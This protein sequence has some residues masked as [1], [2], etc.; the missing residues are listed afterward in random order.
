[1]YGT[2]L[3]RSCI[4]AALGRTGPTG[5]PALAV[6]LPLTA[7]AAF[8]I[9]PTLPRTSGHSGPGLSGRVGTMRR[10]ACLLALV[11]AAGLAGGCVERKYTVYTDPPNALVLVNNT[12]L[13]ASPADGSFV[14]YGKYNF[15][16]M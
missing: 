9:T 16:L 6:K 1:M 10:C 3:R 4:V 14:Y 2:P 15:T 12:P 11:L 13:G 7:G 5:G 8:I